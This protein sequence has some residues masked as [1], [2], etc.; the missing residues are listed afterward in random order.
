MSEDAN[1]VKAY[2]HYLEHIPRIGDC[3]QSFD[4]LINRMRKSICS[5]IESQ[6]LRLKGIGT[7]E[8]TP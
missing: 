8:N 4:S 1:T 3:K 7:A 6:K 5:Q 2:R